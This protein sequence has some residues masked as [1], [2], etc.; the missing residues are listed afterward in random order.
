MSK[1]TFAALFLT[2]LVW[3]PAAVLAQ[4]DALITVLQK[5]Q[6]HYNQ[7]QYAEAE[8]FARRALELI[9]TEFGPNHLILAGI[10]NNLAELYRL[11]GR[12]GVEG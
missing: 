7:G 5:L 10:L 6:T 12:Y 11:Q 9:E 1:R 3:W 8:R 4:S 2:L